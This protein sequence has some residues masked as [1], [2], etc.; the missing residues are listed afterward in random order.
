MPDPDQL[1]SRFVE[2]L[3][4]DAPRP[5]RRFARGA[6]SPA[7]AILAVMIFTLAGLVIDGGR[8][9]GARSRAVGYAQEAAR[10]G[11]AAIQLNSAEAKIDTT[12][13]ATAIA[14]F[15]GQVQSNDPTVTSCGPT[16]LTEKEVD[17]QVDILN[18]TTFLGLIGKQSLKASG[19]GQAHA[20]QGVDKADD[21][22]TIPP[23]VVNSSPDGPGNIPITTAV[24][25]TID[26]PC[27]T[28]TVGSPT[29][30]WT[31]TPFPFP[32]T[33]KPNVT[34]TPTPTPDPSGTPSTTPTTPPK[35][36]PT[37]RPKPS[38]TPRR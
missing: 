23:I 31:L 20:E 32:A 34:P 11:A 5:H 37:G 18:K 38:K 27:P 21:S 6:L 36:V 28:W 22:P 29:P 3:R 7:V 30:V 10:V 15:C 16:T 8:Q 19:V 4:I 26:L 1:R 25:P 2:F 13:A 33:C 17:I 35:S 14:G 12:K 24:P 9:L